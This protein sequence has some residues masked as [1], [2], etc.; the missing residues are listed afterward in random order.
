MTS[1]RLTL[2]ISGLACIVFLTAAQ[3]ATAQEAVRDSL[4]TWQDASKQYSVEAKLIDYDRPTRTVTLEKEDGSQ[5]SLPLEKL[6]QVDRQLILGPYIRKARA[7]RKAKQ[8]EKLANISEDESEIASGQVSNQAS[9]RSERSS[10]AEDGNPFELYGINWIR[11]VDNAS[12]IAT[13][14]TE[15]TSDDRPIMLFRVLGDLE[16]FM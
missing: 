5:I 12:R 6:C 11:G 9:Q 7:E 2:L 16:G 1:K 8:K 3:Q 4:R 13:A 10:R 15:K 14:G